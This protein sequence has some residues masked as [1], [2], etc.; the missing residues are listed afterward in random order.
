MSQRL[1]LNSNRQVNVKSKCEKHC[2][3]S[4]AQS[5][6]MAFF[7]DLTFGHYPYTPYGPILKIGWLEQGH[8]FP[9]GKVPIPFLE[10]LQTMASNPWDHGTAF[11]RGFHT[12]DLELK[13][14][15]LKNYYLSSISGLLTTY[16]SG[17]GE[18]HV[19]HEGIFYAAPVMIYE[20]IV[21]NGYQPPK[22]FIHAILEGEVVTNSHI[23]DFETVDQEL[24]E[25]QPTEK[26]F[27][28]IQKSIKKATALREKGNSQ[29]AIKILNAARK[30]TPNSLAILFHLAQLNDDL[31]NHSRVL[32][33]MDQ[34]QKISANEHVSYGYQGSALYNL[35][36]YAESKKIFQMILPTAMNEGNKN[37]VQVLYYLGKIA[38]K[39]NDFDLAVNY[40]TEANRIDPK[41]REIHQLLKNNKRRVKY[42]FLPTFMKRML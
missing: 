36:R 4:S 9:T 5:I 20:Y 8:D 2:F 34:F 14:E 22:E 18:F 28:R 11:T 1:I 10:K 32:A 37:P 13:N 39:E 27:E 26:E 12:N 24:A 33:L 35:K 19:L 31:R 16:P 15:E 25:D 29:Q 17:N 40:F 7:T 21:E 3:S 23:S 38:E 42:D 41:D 6:N 30:E